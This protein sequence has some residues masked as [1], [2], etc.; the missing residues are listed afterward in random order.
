[1]RARNYFAVLI[2][3]IPPVLRLH[4]RKLVAVTLTL[5]Y[6][7]FMQS[8][9]TPATGQ[10][11]VLNRAKLNE[12]RMASGIRSEA[13][14]ARRLGVDAATLYRLSNGSAVPGNRFIT[15][16]KLAFPMCSLDDLLTLER[17]S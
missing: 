12:L 13:E 6:V 2:R 4:L 10:R 9:S 11:L 7:A 17:A 8:D 15:G 16:L 1:L 5:V 3:N 14:L